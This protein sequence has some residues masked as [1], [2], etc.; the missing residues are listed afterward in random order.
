MQYKTSKLIPFFSGCLFAIFLIVIALVFE[1][2][3]DNKNLLLVLAYPAK[4]GVWI[5]DII[6]W[7]ICKFD[8]NDLCRGLGLDGGPLEWIEWTGIIGG[9]IVGYGLIFLLV[10][11]LYQKIKK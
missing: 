4:I 9:L 5:S 3:I 7:S 10:Y 6:L 2:H 11:I 1:K 8:T